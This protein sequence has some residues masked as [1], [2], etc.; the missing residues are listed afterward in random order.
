MAQILG[1]ADLHGF[2]E[3][4]GLVGGW[5]I[6]GVEV[7]KL[8]SRR[9]GDGVFFLVEIF[10]KNI[11]DHRMKFSSMSFCSL[12]LTPSRSWSVGCIMPHG[13][14]SWNIIEELSWNSGRDLYR[15]F[16]K[17]LRV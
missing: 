7:L 5:S 14:E 9:D 11:F 2:S 1:F 17:N 10:Q 6:E 3:E 12:S 13:W 4:F 8:E 15:R 16:M